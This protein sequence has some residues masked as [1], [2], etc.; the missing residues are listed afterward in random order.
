MVVVLVVVLLIVCRDILVA[1]DHFGLDAAVVR[2]NGNRG[3]GRSAPLQLATRQTLEL[4][5]DAIAHFCRD[6]VAERF[7]LGKVQVVVVKTVTHVE[8]RA[9]EQLA[10]RLLPQIRRHVFAEKRAV[11]G[12]FVER[13]QR[14]QLERLRGVVGGRF[15]GGR[16]TVGGFGGWRL[17]ILGDLSNLGDLGIVRQLHAFAS[18]RLALRPARQ[19]VLAHRSVL[20]DQ[21]LRL[22]FLRSF[23]T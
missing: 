23:G 2:G 10:Q 5:F 6:D 4:R 8:L 7:G 3:L 1:I 21:F 19:E 15:A 20:S 13:L 11:V 12:V 22:R 17:R 18:H 16:R 14:R 9:L